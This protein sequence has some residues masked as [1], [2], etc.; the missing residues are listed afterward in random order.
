[1]E[2]PRTN[3]DLQTLWL[4]NNAQMFLQKHNACSTKW[5]GVG[6][7]LSATRLAKSLLRENLQQFLK[8]GYLMRDQLTGNDPNQTL[9]RETNPEG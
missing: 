6:M 9:L 4:N 5:V 3:L 8:E 7:S 2:N 1:M